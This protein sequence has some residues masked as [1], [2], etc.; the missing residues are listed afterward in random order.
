MQQQCFVIK[1]WRKCNETYNYIS[2]FSSH[3]HIYSA[4][5]FRWHVQ[6]HF[7]QLREKKRLYIYSLYIFGKQR[8]LDQNSHLKK[9][10]ILICKPK[11][12]TVINN[13]KICFNLKIPLKK[14][15]NATLYL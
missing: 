10:I 11:G 7:F 3:I 9:N 14:V 13:I 2:R 8:M 5:H 12:L 4:S 1:I 15:T 6:F